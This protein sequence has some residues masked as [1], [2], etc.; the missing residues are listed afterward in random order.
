MGLVLNDARSDMLQED[1]APNK[2][3]DPKY[4][5]VSVEQSGNLL[6]GTLEAEQKPGFYSIIP[7]KAS[8]LRFISKDGDVVFTRKVSRHPYP[9]AT[10]AIERYFAEKKPWL[11]EQM[12]DTVFD[13]VYNAR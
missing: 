1:R 10:P 11:I 2:Y 13:V 6:I 4:V 3:L 12:E 7:T 8:I 9:N 5:G